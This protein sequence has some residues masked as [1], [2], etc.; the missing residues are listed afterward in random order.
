VRARKGGGR[1]D[2]DGDGFCWGNKEGGRKKG[3]RFSLTRNEGEE[4]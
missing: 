3:E 1:G 2:G 4:R